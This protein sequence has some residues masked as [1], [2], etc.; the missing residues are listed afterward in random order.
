MKKK[1]NKTIIATCLILVFPFIACDDYMEV[2]PYGSVSEETLATKAGVTNLL[3]GAYSLIDGVNGSF[4][5]GDNSNWLFS[6]MAS[7][8]ATRG[9][10]SNANITFFE[11]HTILPTHEYVEKKW[12]G[13]YDGIQRANDVLRILPK[14]SEKELPAGEAT[15]IKAEAMFIRG[16]LHYEL[17]K[18][19]KNVPYIDE[20]VIYNSDYLVPNTDRVYPK[21]EADFQFAADNLAATKSDAGRANSWAAKSFLAVVQMQQGKY[22]EALPL[23]TDIVTNGVTASGDKYALVPNY[24]DNFKASTENNSE[25]VFAVQYTVNDGASGINGNQGRLLGQPV[26]P[27]CAGGGSSTVS[28]STVNAF[29]TDP[30]TGLPLPDTYNDSDITNDMGLAESAPFTPYT[31]TL[32]PRLDLTVG[33]RD[34]P[35]LDWGLMRRSWG[36]NQL[37]RGCYVLKKF[38]FYKA[39]L[40]VNTESFG[41]WTTINNINYCFIRFA[42]ILL[43]AAE[44]EVETGSLAKAEQYVNMVR[45]RAADPVGWVKTYL[46]NDPSRGFTDTPAANYFVG[47]YNGQF[48]ANGQAYARKA[49]RFERRLELACEGHRFFDLQRW[50]NG[51]GYMA[52]ELNAVIAHERTTP[53][54][55]PALQNAVFTK[56]RNE[57]YPIPQAQIDLSMKDEESVLVQN[58]N[59]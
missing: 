34:I 33:R 8:E 9:S 18:T 13:C 36:P 4:F 54:T 53:A 1:L 52:D 17:A 38:F 10:T 37:E 7:H 48:T 30:G 16:L 56:G 14:V 26:V 45:A 41:G 47:L 35:L 15:Q 27:P 51:T 55:F 12:D 23:L 44:C 50:D 20:T 59:Y 58:P 21:I 43:R 6:D 19:W 28:F 29:K 5:W 42:D 24:W 11:A 32:D 22:S 2:S 40:D 49:V 3:T 57:I 39:D 46:D 25:S 31:G